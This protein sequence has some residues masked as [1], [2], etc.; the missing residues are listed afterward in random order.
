MS[1]V[2]LVSYLLLTLGFFAYSYGFVD[3]NLT[4]TSN[5]SILSLISKLQH[6]VYFDRP[7]SGNI[8]LLFTLGFALLYLWTLKSGK[9]LTKFPWPKII[10]LSLILTLC[11]PMFSYDVYN[12][13]F[14]SKIIW[15]YHANPHI[16]PP[17]HFEG[18]PWLRFMRWVHTPAAYGYGHTLLYSPVYLLGLGKFTLSL[19]IAKLIPYGFYLWSIKL[20]GEIA[21]KLKSVKNIPLLQLTYA[22]NPLILFETLVNSHNDGIMMA[23]Y[24]LAILLFLKNK[25]K[26]SFIS[27]FYGI[28]IKL[29]AIVMVPAYF[30][31]RYLSKDQIIFFSAW[32]L[33]LPL[34]IWIDR[35][36]PWY[37]IWFFTASL[38]TNSRITIIFSSLMTILALYYYFPYVSTGFWTY[39]RE[40]NFLLTFA[41]PL[42]YLFFSKIFAKHRRS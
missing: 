6:L 11:Y 30:L 14:H 39:T 21:H 4:L 7:L 36:Q 15:H 41:A 33:Y 32:L 5:P 16:Y 9:K 3:L 34:L 40:F 18:D 38:L 22:L 26:Q 42:I 17:L 20:I 31:Q 29:M 13:M 24:L 10:I 2:I 8:Y 28:S 37:L 19:L 1:F 23:F 27:L 25:Y 35:F 12:Y